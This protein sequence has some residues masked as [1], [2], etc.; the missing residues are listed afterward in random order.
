MD[1]NSDLKFKSTLLILFYVKKIET[2]GFF[3][4]WRTKNTTL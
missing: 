2:R 4:K 1:T 3:K